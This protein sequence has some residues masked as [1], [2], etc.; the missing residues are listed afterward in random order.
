MEE[1]FLYFAYGSNLFKKRIRIN[2]PTAEFIGIGRLDC[3]QLDFIKYSDHWRGASATILPCENAHIWG[4]VWRLNIKDMPSLDWQEGVDTNWYFPKTV[5]I[6]TPE[7]TTVQCRTYQQV[8]NPPLREPNEELPQ[9]RRPSS[10]YLD[11]IING[12]LEC[13]LPEEYIKE[14]QKIPHNGQK[15]SPK[16]IEKLNI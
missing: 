4:A 7:G 14:L 9:E 15:A 10:T 3:H 11:C 1:T 2:N 16:M 6:I 12:A 8:V 5:D 13:N